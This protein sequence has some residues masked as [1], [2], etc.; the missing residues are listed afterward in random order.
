MISCTD[1]I[2]AYSEFFIFL[3]ENYGREEVDRCWSA[4]FKPDGNGGPLVNFVLREGI[5]GC[6]SYWSGT[7]NEEAADF[8]MYLN[9]KRGW[10]MLCMHRC[11][12]KGKLLHLQ[13][14]IGLKP[15]R[16]YCLHCDHYR[17][18]VEKAGLTYIYNFMGVD[19]AACS[20]LIYDP[21]IFD[22]RIIVD[23]DTQIMDRK[24]ADNEYFHPGFH[25]SMSRCLHYLGENH[26]KQAVADC[27]AAYTRHVHAPLIRD[28]RARGLQALAEDIRSTYQKEKAPDA[29][30]L[31][32]TENSLQVTVAY[33]PAVQYMNA[34]GMWISSWFRASTECVMQAIADACG[35]RFTMEAY[36]DSTGSA[37]YRFDSK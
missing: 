37:R 15:Y 30:S 25:H 24:A 8:T 2:P 10:F 22:G 13:K 11:P 7:L 5:R 23:E 32:L 14:Q 19:Q 3:E 16:D 12:S 6:Y 20:I 29:V 33:C 35:Y 1:F 17:A 27:L 36:D 9:E 21:K 26:G 18:A 4:L 31:T 28:I 34:A